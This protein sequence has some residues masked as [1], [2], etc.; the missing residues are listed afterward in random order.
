MLHKDYSNCYDVYDEED[1]DQFLC[2]RACS[3]DRMNS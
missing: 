2:P 1:T 3:T